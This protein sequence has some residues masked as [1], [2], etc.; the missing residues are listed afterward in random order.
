VQPS[1][2][3]ACLLRIWPGNIRELTAEVRSAAQAALA[4]DSPRLEAKHLSPQA[5]SALAIA[6]ASVRSAAGDAPARE[7][8]RPRRADDAEPARAPSTGSHAPSKARIAGALKRHERN[9]S[10]AARDLDLHRTQLRR[11]ME[12]YG[13]DARAFAPKGSLP[14]G[15][16]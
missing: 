3:E 2:I 8:H 6:E 13:L 15:E 16:E 1:L 10:G 12:R 9:V 4:S 11:W 5:G 14:P 7:S